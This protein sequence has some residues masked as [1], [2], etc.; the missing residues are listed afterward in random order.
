MGAILVVAAIFGGAAL[1]SNGASDVLS[2]FV[3]N[4]PVGPATLDPAEEC[5]FTDMTI[6]EAV[7]A[8]LTQYGSKPG[9]NGTTQ[10]DPGHIVPYLARSWDITKG[11]LVYT[12]HLRSGVKFPS[13]KPVDA[14][15]VRYSFERSIKMAGC[16]GYFIYD[17]IYK[18][19]L[20]RSIEALDPTTVRITLN[21]ADANVL[22]DWAQPAA[23]IVDASLVNAHGGVQ[24]GK[25]N[26]WMS[27]HVA[28]VGPYT[29][30]SYEANKRA[31]LVATP[32][33]FKQ[34]KSRKVI[35]NFI[36]SDPTLLL[37]ARNG[38]AD[39]TL[40]LSKQSAHSLATNSNLKLIANNTSSAEQIGLP[41][42]KPPFGNAT[43]REALTY[44]VPYEQILQ[45]VAFGYGTLYYGAYP[46]AMPEFRASLEKARAFDLSKA[47]AL[48][49]QSGVQTPVDVTMDIQAGNSIDEQVATIV[50]G[51][52]QQLGVHVTIDKLSPSDYI[53]KL[54]QHK[55]Q[56]YI[57]LDGPGVIEAGYY[58]GYD[59]KC[60]IG[61]NLSAICIKK[62]DALLAKGRNTFVK[63]KRQQIWNEINTL[64]KA[65]SPKIP[66]Y[67]DKYVSVLN[68]RVK[69]YFYSHE[70]DFTTWSR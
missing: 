5:G 45:K 48:V 4:M 50:Q 64:W 39:V 63:A 22:Q 2:A 47:E 8:R 24:K 3:I 70:V 6:T 51:I 16:G 7:Y 54:E 65:D 23:S 53:N 12:F 61:F 36:S 27:G 10:V 37:Q 26:T 18:P 29:L 38:S 33:F 41:H 42:D 58:L 67:G 30:Q 32:G 52:W 1:E 49:A 46:P 40:G 59:L 13:G 15:A 57:R 20:I 62:A 9:P 14:N 28:G 66:V 43:F 19:P 56:S 68:T 21:Q 44:A 55:S 69:H 11:G 60:G 31:V 17:G 34:P 35:V 25:V